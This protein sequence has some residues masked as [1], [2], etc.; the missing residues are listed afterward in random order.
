MEQIEHQREIVG[1]GEPR[2]FAAAGI[3]VLIAGVQWQREQ[4]LGAPFETVLA[5]VARLDRG[6]AMP[7]EYVN[8]LLEEMFLRRRLGA[9]GEVEDEDR[10]EVA[11]TLEVN[12]AAVDPEARPR[13]GRHLEQIDAEIFGDRHAFVRRPR[14]VGVNQHFGVRDVGDR[15]VHALTSTGFCPAPGF[16]GSIR[17]ERDTSTRRW[18]R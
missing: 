18:R 16:G 5:S 15:L 12:E 6:V 8:D 10:D 14:R 3:E 13:R 4:A 9:G 1:G 7:G 11:A 17:V 2:A